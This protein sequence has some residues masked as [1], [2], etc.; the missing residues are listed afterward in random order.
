MFKVSRVYALLSGYYVGK[1][2]RIFSV[3]I[4]VAMAMVV[5]GDT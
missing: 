3:V 2:L 5:M 1:C 4:F